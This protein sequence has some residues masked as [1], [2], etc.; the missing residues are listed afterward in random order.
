MAGIRR[1][2][3][4]LAAGAFLGTVAIAAIPEAARTEP[5]YGQAGG[6]PVPAKTGKTVDRVPAAAVGSWTWGS[7][8]PGR[9]V[10][11][12]TG[13]YAGHAG[14]G[15]VSYLFS[16]DGTF[17]RYVLIHLG[18]G[19][20]NENVFSAMEG[21]VSFNESAGTFTLRFTKGTITFEKKSGMTKRPLTREDM[22]RGG[23]VFTYRFEKDEDGK[24]S[25][26]VND[27]DKAAREGRAFRRDVDTETKG[28]RGK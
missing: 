1:P 18:A 14:G 22:E 9:Y 17:R 20:A 6:S 12:V 23:T 4:L 19:F 2:G 7:V 8:N 27:R 11:R 15:A 26:W 25:L 24:V 10:N 16:P 21:R 28:D 13:E 5:L 3:I